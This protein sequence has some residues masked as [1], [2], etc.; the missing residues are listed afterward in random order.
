M[1]SLAPAW[2][3]ATAARASV[4]VP[5][6]T[7]GAWMCSASSPRTSV[8][9]IDGDVDHQQIGAAAG[10]QHGKRLGVVGGVRDGGA[11]LHCQ[12]G[13]GRQLAVQCADDQKPHDSYSF[14][15]S[16]DERLANGVKGKT[17]A[18]RISYSRF[19]YS[20]FAHL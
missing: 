10:A 2:M 14:F 19:R 12:L 6:A 13:R 3:A 9:D 16:G 17:G 1:Y 4:A 18:L 5:Q 7:I 8:A 15:A 11:L 20:P